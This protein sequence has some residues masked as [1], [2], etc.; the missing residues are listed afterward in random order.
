MVRTTSDSEK[1]KPTKQTQNSKIAPDK[2]DI[3]KNVRKFDIK[4]YQPMFKQIVESTNIKFDCKGKGQK[5][6]YKIKSRNVISLMPNGDVLFNRAE[7]SDIEGSKLFPDH[8]KLYVSLEITN[9]NIEQVIRDYLE[10]HK[11]DIIDELST[12]TNVKPKQKRKYS[13]DPIYDELLAKCQRPVPN[14]EERTIQEIWTTKQERDQFF[15]NALR[16]IYNDKC[17]ICGSQVY[18][19]KGNPEAEMAHIKPFGKRHKGPDDVRNG[20][21]LCRFHHWA[22]DHGLFSISDN[23]KV[24]ISKSLPEND[25]YENIIKF[26]GEEIFIPQT[27]FEPDKKFLKYHRKIHGF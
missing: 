27:S 9:A 4:N 20:L 17:A 10:K 13:R 5:I 18:D 22:F 14:E 24:L 16:I 15:R 23:Y 2:T 8:G 11:Q 21:A 1:A 19:L 7:Q 26:E 12:N 6:S 25:N 3:S